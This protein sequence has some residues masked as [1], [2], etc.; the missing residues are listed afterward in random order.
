MK[1]LTKWVM[2]ALIL[3]FAAPA[4]A[5]YSG[6]CGLW[7]TKR[8]DFYS[9]SYPGTQAGADAAKAYVGNNGVIQVFSGCEGVINWGTLPDSVMVIAL[10]GNRWSVRGTAS[11]ARLGPYST[12]TTGGAVRIVDGITFAQ[13]NAGVQAA[14][15]EVKAAGGGMVLMPRG[16]YR[17]TSNV[18][19]ADA[20]GITFAGVGDSTALW[21]DYST[22]DDCFRVTGASKSIVFQSFSY[23][24]DWQNNNAGRAIDVESSTSYDITVDRVTVLRTNDAAIASAAPRTV[25]R[26]CK[27][28]QI[29]DGSAGDRR[30]IYLY[31]GTADSSSIED[32]DVRDCKD[33]SFIT[34]A[35]TDYLRVVNNRFINA[36]GTGTTNNVSVNG[37]GGKFTNFSGNTVDGSDLGV[38]ALFGSDSS[39]IV[40]NVFTNCRI[41]SGLY[42]LRGNGNVIANNICTY[43]VHQGIMLGFDQ[44]NCTGN[45]IE[46]N[47]CANNQGT[48]INV[49]PS[50]NRV[51]TNNVIQ[52][53]SC[54]NNGGWGITT[55]AAT[56]GGQT[57]SI[58]PNVLV[59]NTSGGVSLQTTNYT[60]LSP[61]FDS[62][63]LV[64]GPTTGKLEFDQAGVNQILA[65]NATGDMTIGVRNATA[66]TI[67]NNGVT[68]AGALFVG[69]NVT[70]PNANEYRIKDTGGTARAL[71]SMG[72]TNSPRFRPLAAATGSIFFQNFAADT[73]HFRIFPY[74]GLQGKW[75]SDNTT[76]GWIDGEGARYWSVTP[77]S[78]R[79][80]TTIAG[81]GA[82]G[83]ITIIFGNANTTVN[84]TNNIN[85][86]GAASW[87]PTATGST[88][89]LL[90]DGGTSKWVE[91]A[92][93]SN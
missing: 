32:N 73:T 28:Y 7:A 48:G 47:L 53:N 13:T 67:D 93:S 66:I 75:V 11:I 70:I 88:L 19:I 17:W 24:G 25:V 83:E 40:S 9:K 5:A 38:L 52:N 27:I 18:N 86:Q 61:R 2:A 74:G 82:G 76:N 22:G 77:G 80:V 34:D 90:F 49:T 89:T 55:S 43:N 29:G 60:Y 56:L 39:R 54:L 12:A 46:G 71:V 72:G 33:N 16:R 6:T 50:T 8:N 14:Y 65:S 91:V 36:V 1:R 21:G 92:R 85:L 69:T 30:G 57:V 87:N 59:G 15:A 51:H 64:R 23:D 4:F 20:V 3:A 42:F 78:A 79:T 63:V 58:G 26:E 10:E 44:G 31:N 35:N 68:T 37:S 41:Y 84:E 45:L 81:S 62:N